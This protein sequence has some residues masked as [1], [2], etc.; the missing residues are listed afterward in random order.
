MKSEDFIEVID[1][2][3]SNDICN[4]TITAFEKLTELGY[5]YSRKDH[6][7]AAKLYKDDTSVNF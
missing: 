4:Q 2:A 5:C 1:N 7:G 3:V 6:E